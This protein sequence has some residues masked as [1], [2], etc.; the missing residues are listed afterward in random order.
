M[1]TLQ[2]GTFLRIP[3]ADGTFGYGRK[4]DEPYTAFYNHRTRQPSD[5]LDAIEA[6]PVL[7]TVAV[8]TSTIKAWA[9]LGKRKLTGEVAKPV[10]GFH[11]DA[12]DLDKCIIFDTTGAERPATPDECEGLERDSSWDAHHV[13]SR[14][15]DTFEGRPNPFAERQRPGRSPR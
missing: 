10:V 11:Q 12:V 8:R 9:R 13:E 7:F 5:D 6:R 15:L 14:L 2:P 3:L 4:L 1:A